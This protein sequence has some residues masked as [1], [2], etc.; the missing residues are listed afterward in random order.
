MGMTII[1]ALKTSSQNGVSP[2]P[3][4]ATTAGRGMSFL[5]IPDWLINRHFSSSGISMSGSVRCVAVFPF[6]GF[7][8]GIKRGFGGFI[9]QYSEN[10]CLASQRDSKSYKCGEMEVRRNAAVDIYIRSTLCVPDSRTIHDGLRL[11]PRPRQL[12]R[13]SSSSWPTILELIFDSCSIW[14]G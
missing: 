5:R 2:S 7:A 10:C 13:P 14:I 12:A 1:A 8:I 9:L 11:G 4:S 6:R 3:S